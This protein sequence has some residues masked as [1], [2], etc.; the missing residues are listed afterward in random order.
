[1][2]TSV[3]SL[4]GASCVTPWGCLLS[5]HSEHTPAWLIDKGIDGN[6]GFTTCSLKSSLILMA[7][8]PEDIKSKHFEESGCVSLSVLEVYY[9]FLL[10]FLVY[11]KIYKSL[12]H[13]LHHFYP[14]HPSWK[15]KRTNMIFTRNEVNES[16]K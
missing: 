5:G 12:R 2:G 3:V 11:L 6:C 15:L 7:L 8:L 16:E 9:Q 10:V 4:L 1:M 14:I 13:K